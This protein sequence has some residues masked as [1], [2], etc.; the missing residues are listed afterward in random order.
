MID[1][2]CLSRITT[3]QPQN[4]HIASCCNREEDAKCGIRGKI[5][6]DADQSRQ[7][8]ENDGWQDCPE[9]IGIDRKCLTDMG[10]WG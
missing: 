7:Q 2:Q 3:K 8:T 4:Q 1:H 9:A 5:I 6:H 10:I